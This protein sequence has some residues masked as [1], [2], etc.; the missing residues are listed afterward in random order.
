MNI[1]YLD[2][3]PKLAAKYHC[4]K[5]VVKM[6][7]ETAQLLCTAHR[8]L[9]GDENQPEYVYKATHKNHPSAVWARTNIEN[10]NWLYQLFLELN[11]EYTYRYGKTHLSYKKL[12][13][14]LMHP[15]N[16]ITKGAFFP[17]PQCMP[18]KYKSMDTVL[19][20]KQYYVG[21]KSKLLQYKKE[22]P[23]WILAMEWNN[24]KVNQ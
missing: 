3:N 20:Y 19:A 4:D 22:F 6:I 7:L 8:L 21:D 24:W 11:E 15:P 5:H 16:N 18:D 17:P 13:D 9:D 14:Y 23:L 10:Y 12:N 1:F 2:K